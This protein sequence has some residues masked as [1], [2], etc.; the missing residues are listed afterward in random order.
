MIFCDQPWYNEPGREIN[1]AG[2]DQ[3]KAYNRTLYP[4]TVQYAMLDWLEKKR[5]PLARGRL[6]STGR[7]L[8]GPEQNQA[9]Q[10]TNNDIW[11]EIVKKHFESKE[12][13]IKATVDK[14]MAGF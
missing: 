7:R 9:S 11:Q 10:D 12:K 3:S 2:D 13:E 8:G 14:W 1:S 4:G 6:Y 5:Y